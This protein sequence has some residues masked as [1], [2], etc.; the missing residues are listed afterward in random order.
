MCVSVAR[1]VP[2]VPGVVSSSC[3]GVS[4]RQRSM[5]FVVAQ[6]SCCICRCRNGFARVIASVS[7][8]LRDLVRD[9]VAPRA[10]LRRRLAVSAKDGRGLRAVLVPVVNEL[11]EHDADGRPVVATAVADNAV[12]IVLRGDLARAGA[13]QGRGRPELVDGPALA[14]QLRAETLAGQQI[15][16]ELLA[17]DDVLERRVQGAVGARCREVQRFRPER[18][19][20]LEQGRVRPGVVPQH[21]I[22]S[23]AHYVWKSGLPRLMNLPRPFFPSHLSFSTTTSPRER[24]VVALPFTL[25]PS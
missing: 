2:Y 8:V 22:E 11:R 5:S 16:V 1:M 19:A 25:R 10:D 20:V 7:V 18:R 3:S 21:V 12:R 15:E 9:A 17:A 13:R 23:R 6:M 4:F 24:T 14:A